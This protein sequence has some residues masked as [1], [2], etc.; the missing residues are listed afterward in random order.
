VIEERHD[1]SGARRWGV[2]GAFG[3][4]TQ[5]RALIEGATIKSGREERGCGGHLGAPHA[6]SERK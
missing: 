2:W 4:P 3:V 6:R 5:E 1:Q